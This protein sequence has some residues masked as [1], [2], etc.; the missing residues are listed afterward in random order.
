MLYSLHERKRSIGQA[1]NMGGRESEKPGTSSAALEAQAHGDGIA[2]GKVYL[3]CCELRTRNLYI[4][5][6]YRNPS[7]R[8][9]R[10][11]E[12]GMSLFMH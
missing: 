3:Y 10:G 5:F 12:V 7:T 6:K 2:L 4:H 11:H 8:D 1:T 9:N